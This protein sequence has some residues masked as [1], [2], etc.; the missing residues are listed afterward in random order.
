MVWLLLSAGLVLAILVLLFPWKERPVPVREG[1]EGRIDER[2]IMFS[3]AG[4]EP[5]TER[6]AGFY[7]TYPAYQAPDDVWRAL[8]G[9]LRPGSL[10]YQPFLFRA[11][12][13]TFYTV[14]GLHDLTDGPVDAGIPEY[15]PDVLLRFLR[16]WASGMGAHSMGVTR[17]KKSHLY[18]VG[19]RNH[20][21]GQP[22]VNEH[23][24]AIA[25]TV[26]MDSRHV[27]SS[28]R[29]PIVMESSRQY[30]SSGTMAVQV[31][32]WLRSLGYE[33]RAHIDGHYD[34]R[35]TLVARDAGLGEIGR[36]GLLMT[37]RLGPR[38]RIAV[39]TTTAPLPVT[40]AV[41]DGSVIRFC[42]SCKKCALACPAQAIPHDER[43]ITNG[44]LQWTI[45]QEKCFTYWCKA[46]TDCGRC[47]AVCPYSHPDNLLH[48]SVRYLIRRAPLFRRLA[49]RADDWI[50]GK[51]PPSAALPAWMETKN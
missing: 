22:V 11:A 39:V 20:N 45:S 5:G 12:E 48:Q 21:Y 27:K 24:H 17:L 38:V 7:Q 28:P 8:P 9:L 36:M 25:L 13:S 3:R 44:A 40:P 29:G 46:G 35:C 18:S 30:L 32:A 43:H 42:Q 47:I 41:P 1:E 49:V 50:Y 16:G 23:S 6:F 37:P 19:G 4:L 14:G 34:L 15:D 26:E 51:K 33:A 10:F 31:A 2:T